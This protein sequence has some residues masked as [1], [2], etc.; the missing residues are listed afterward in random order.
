MFSIGRQIVSESKA[1]MKASNG[2]K[3]L[4]GGRD[5]LSIL[6]KA[7]MST[8]IPETQRLNDAE[9]ISRVYLCYSG[10]LVLTTSRRDPY[11][12]PRR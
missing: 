11:I 3:T 9:V 10:T 1:N 12:F 6:L 4:G 2:E 5:L 7:N 8:N